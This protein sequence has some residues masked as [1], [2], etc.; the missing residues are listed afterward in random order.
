MIKAMEIKIQKKIAVMLLN[1]ALESKDG[2]LLL[3]H[4]QMR[5]IEFNSIFP[6]NKLN[7]SKFFKMI[8]FKLNFKIKLTKEIK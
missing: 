4:N 6:L 5:L 3:T 7:F 1:K 8:K 2:K